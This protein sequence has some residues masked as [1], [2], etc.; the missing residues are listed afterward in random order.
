MSYYI[1]LYKSGIS[2]YEDKNLGLPSG[3]GNSLFMADSYI[4][5][6]VLEYV[7]VN[8]NSTEVLLESNIPWNTFFSFLRPSV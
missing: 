8:Q 4:F 7:L 3:L 5:I 6:V 2:T 1:P